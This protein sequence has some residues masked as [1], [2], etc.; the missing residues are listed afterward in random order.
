MA[1]HD[2]YTY[3]DSDVLINKRGHRSQALLQ[4]YEWMRTVRRALDLPTFPLSAQGIQSLHHHLFQDVYDWAGQY[5]TVNMTKEGAPFLHK[6]Q[7]AEALVSR[8][9]QLRWQNNLKDM[10]ADRFARGAAEHIA[11]LNYIHPFREGNGRVM[12]FHLEHLAEQAGHVLDLTRIQAGPW[13]RGSKAALSNDERLL[14]HA[15]ALM[16][17]PQRS[18]SVT[19]A[20][21]EVRDLRDTAVAEIRDRIAETQ[22][23]IQRGKGTT[24][25]TRALRDMRDELAVIEGSGRGSILRLLEEAKTSGIERIDVL[26]GRDGSARD[27]IHAIGRGAVRS[28]DLDRD[29][30][31]AAS[32][33][34]TPAA[35]NVVTNSADAIPAPK[36]PSSSPGMS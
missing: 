19:Q 21:S 11:D 24:I 27:A 29:R 16:L 13:D 18:V 22:A 14:T 26:P 1:G 28:L 10:S 6:D 34:V 23:A 33:G 32:L 31:V 30:K 35:A 12:K 25:T 36:R 15:I 9:Q 2:P 8:F 20:V 7:I 17:A 5:R 3:P 4:N